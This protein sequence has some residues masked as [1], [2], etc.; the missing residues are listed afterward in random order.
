MKKV[1]LLAP[2][3]LPRR[4]VSV[5]RPFKFAI[6]LKEFGWQPHIITLNSDGNLTDRES[7]LLEDIPIYTI[8]SPIDFTDRSESSRVVHTK[9]ASNPES[10]NKSKKLSPFLKL[11]DRHFPIDTWLPLFL[12]RERYIRKIINNINPDLIWSTGD[13]WSGHIIANRIAKHYNKPWV[14]DF[15]DPWNLG[16][17][18]LKER[19]AFSSRID[20]YYEDKL[21]KNASILTFTAKATEQLYQRYFG[22]YNLRTATL[23]NS[24]DRTL[25]DTNGT[26]EELFNPEYLNLIF[27]GSFRTRSPAAVFIEVLSRL[28]K[29][30]TEAAKKIRMYCF[31]ALNETDKEKAE[32]AQVAN[33]F[34][35]IDSVPPEQALKF[36][37]NAD[38]LWLSTTGKLKNIIPAKLWDYLASETPILSVASNPEIGKILEQTGTG[39]QFGIDNFSPVVEILRKCVKLKM[40]QEKISSLPFY[41][42]AMNVINSFEATQTTGS[43]SQL[44]DSLM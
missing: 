29:K 24:F 39:V 38:L 10:Q 11:I 31:G 9:T 26:E 33:Q 28:Y 35:Q 40:N 19:S 4:R 7:K 5:W 15:R 34:F 6:H 17:M 16:G 41:H 1:V 42:P 12:F 43:L 3:F 25:Y 18:N 37:N 13:P 44:F 23:Y 21:V 27:F 32:Q 36:L 14:A 30:D 20:K 22:E 8:D 2:Y